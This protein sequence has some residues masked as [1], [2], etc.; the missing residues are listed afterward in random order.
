M[1]YFRIVVGELTFFLRLD[2]FESAEE[3]TLFI[4]THRKV[5]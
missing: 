3:S 5:L 4:A 1:V 2:A